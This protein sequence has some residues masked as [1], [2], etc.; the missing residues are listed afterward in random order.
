MIWSIDMDLS[1]PK[2]AQSE[3]DDKRWRECSNEMKCCDRSQAFCVAC[4]DGCFYMDVLEAPAFSDRAS[5]LIRKE[6]LTFP[7]WMTELPDKLKLTDMSIP[8]THDTGASDIDFQKF[9]VFAQTQ[10]LSVGEQLMAG[11]RA[12]DVRCRHIGNKFAIH[13][14]LIYLNLNFDDLLKSVTGFLARHPGEVVLMRIKEEYK[15]AD[16]SRT[17]AQTLQEYINNYSKFFWKSTTMPRLGQARGKIVILDQTPK[18]PGFGPPWSSFKIQDNYDFSGQGCC[19]AGVLQG[20]FREPTCTL[21]NRVEYKWKV[22][23]EFFLETTNGDKDTVY[24]N[25]MSANHPPEAGPNDVA[26]G[27]NQKAKDFFAPSNNKIDRAGWVF[28]DFPGPSLI[29]SILFHN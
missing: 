24:I 22:A 2:R 16:N 3:N 14:D 27:M 18:S 17:F 13:H 4:A 10:T 21:K 23:K 7:E 12:L 26:K 11:I 8:G 9:P 28:M 19:V 5:L 1:T 15:P 20:C 25:F 6:G 29:Y